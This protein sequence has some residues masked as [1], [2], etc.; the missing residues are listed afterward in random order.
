MQTA[1]ITDTLAMIKHCYR[2]CQQQVC[3]FG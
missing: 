2:I 3:C 1:M